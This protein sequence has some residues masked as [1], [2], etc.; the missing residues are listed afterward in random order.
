MAGHGQSGKSKIKIMSDLEKFFKGKKV[1]ITGH[2][3]FKGAWLTKILMMWGAE[4][5]AISLEPHTSPNLFEVLE[6]QKR[7]SHHLVDVTDYEEIKKVFDF[8]KPEIVFHLAAQAIVKVSYDDPLRT[9]HV[10]T[11]GSAN[12]L[13][14]INTT[15]SV[16]SAVMITSDK[17]YENRE[18]VY[19]YR[20]TDRLGGIDPYSASKAAA[21]IIDQSFIACF[22]NKEDSALVAIARAGNVVGGG[23]WSPNRLVPDV[24]RAIYEE[25]K[26]VVTR[27][28]QAIRPWQ[29]V[30]EP[31]SGYLLLS[32]LLFE[33]H[34]DLVTQWNFGPNDENFIPVI[35]LIKR[36]IT[37]LDK[38]SYEIDENSNFHE[39][40][41]LKLDISKAKTDLNWHPKLGI[42]ETLEFTYNWYKN[43]Y[44]KIESPITYTEKQIEDYFSR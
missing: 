38:G 34:K 15:K 42:K 32:K 33:G 24:I 20:E 37:I 21:D 3:G 8:E 35:E 36:G 40:R 16:K 28:P 14:A 12:V 4:V 23:D 18:W 41:F 1:L 19:P 13:Q 39:S 22:L 27:N 17:A 30:L 5:S 11:M 6:L 25:K 10:N 2:T 43:Y 44:E 31:L 9:Y 29:F 7:I 26:A